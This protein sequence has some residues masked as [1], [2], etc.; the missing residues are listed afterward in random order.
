M[1]LC[2]RVFVFPHETW[3]RPK[4]LAPRGAKA[5]MTSCDLLSLPQWKL[6]NRKQRVLWANISRS[7]SFLRCQRQ[8]WQRQR[9][10]QLWPDM[11]EGARWNSLNSL[12]V[13]SI[14]PRTGSYSTTHVLRCLC[15]VF[16]ANQMPLLLRMGQLDNIQMIWALH[17]ICILNTFHLCFMKI[18]AFSSSTLRRSCYPPVVHQECTNFALK[19]SHW[20]LSFLKIPTLYLSFSFSFRLL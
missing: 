13:E 16:S 1:Y 10:Q 20:Y 12:G 17:T 18:W 9:G 2:I 3:C 4:A 19:K 7:L 8:R 11:A 6:F 5:A 15:S 14:A